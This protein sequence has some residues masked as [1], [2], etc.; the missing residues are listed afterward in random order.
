VNDTWYPQFLRIIRRAELAD[1]LRDAALAGRL[2][3]WTRILTDA[4]VAT[5]GELGWRAVAKGHPADF[6]P[7][8]GRRMHQEYLAL[9]VV[10][11]TEADT[12]QPANGFRWPFP[13][14]VFELENS[15][16]P[17]RIAFS[18]WKVLMARAQVRVVFC[19][20]G[21]REEIG[22]LVRMIGKAVI[23][24]LSAADIAAFA[25]GLMIV[26][27]T[28]DKAEAFPYGFF[29]EWILDGQTGSFRRP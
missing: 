24:G 3:D 11:F 23:P 12:R 8:I 26:V 6:M 17:E 20:S 13:A 15:R 22:N 28:R 27:G 9:D 1:P 18:L 29:H 4:V 10:A 19:Y 14:A 2:A 7:A 21:D 25:P 5:C 16:Q